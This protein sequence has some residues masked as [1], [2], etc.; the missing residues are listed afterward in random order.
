[1][2]DDDSASVLTLH[3]RA[4]NKTRTRREGLEGGGGG[5]PTVL[6]YP[7]ALRGNKIESLSQ[8]SSQFDGKWICRE[9]IRA[10]GREW[11]KGSADRIARTLADR[12]LVFY[13]PAS[14]RGSIRPNLRTDQTE[15]AKACAIPDLLCSLGTF[16]SELLDPVA[17]TPYYPHHFHHA[18]AAAAPSSETYLRSPPYHPLLASSPPPRR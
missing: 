4:A 7:A 2:S 12:P 10:V 8:V 9:N 6:T 14:D 13:R 5:Q 16:G 18:A 15:S 1:M 3:P 11:G 17:F